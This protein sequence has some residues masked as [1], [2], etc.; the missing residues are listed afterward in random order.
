MCRKMNKADL[1]DILVRMGPIDV[2][3]EQQQKLDMFADAILPT[4]CV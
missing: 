1:V 4:S 2:Q 3:G